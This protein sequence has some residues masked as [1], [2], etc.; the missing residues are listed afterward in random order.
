MIIYDTETTQQAI[1]FFE[2]NIEL[3]GK[4]R[5][6]E[7][8]RKLSETG[9]ETIFTG[10]DET[11]TIIGGLSSGYSG[12]GSNGLVHVLKKLGVDEGKA[13]TLVMDNKANKKGF[14]H[15]FIVGLD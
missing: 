11:M 7:H 2:N 14:K 4:I 13:E 10:T 12:E 3:L 8:K 1:K 6:I 9:Y 5:S 15:T